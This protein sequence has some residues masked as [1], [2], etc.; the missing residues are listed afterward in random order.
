MA[1][2]SSVMGGGAGGVDV[3][4]AEAFRWGCKNVYSIVNSLQCNISARFSIHMRMS[5]NS[6]VASMPLT[7]PSHSFT[8]RARAAPSLS[9]SKIYCPL[10]NSRSEL[11]SRSIY[12]V[13]TS[14]SSLD[15]PYSFLYLPWWSA[16]AHKLAPLSNKPC[17]AQRGGEL[18]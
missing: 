7:R 4:I 1:A 17:I 18:L 14:A 3:C 15:L 13:S 11:L 2:E 16:P 10:I 8:S 12:S 9:F 5:L 6:V